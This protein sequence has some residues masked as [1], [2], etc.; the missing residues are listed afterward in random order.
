MEKLFIK[1][2]RRIKKVKDQLEKSLDIK[3]NIT[4]DEIEIEGK[5]GLSEYVA[6]RVMEALELGFEINS[7]LQ[8]KNDEFMFE[9]LN[10]K[11]HVRTSRLKTIKGRLI[12]EKGRA[13]EVIS[14]LTDCDIAIKDYDVG[15]IG[16]TSDV[17]VALHA[18]KDIIQGSPHAKVYAYLEKSRKIRMFR[19]EEEGDLNK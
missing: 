14:E 19:V 13:K 8:L 9:K 10:L 4:K 2:I 6:K 1:E 5:E 12:G 18:I 15:I 7:A 11:S 17:D 3:L 16:R